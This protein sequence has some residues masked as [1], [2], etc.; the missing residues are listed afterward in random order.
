MQTRARARHLLAAFLLLLVLAPTR[1]DAY[2]VLTHEQII[3]L[4]WRDTIV[5]LLLSQYPNLTPKQLDEAHAYAYGGCAI[6]DLGY[7]PFGSIFFSDLT[8]YVRTG[9]FVRALFRNAQNAN[10]LAFAIGALSHYLGDTIGHAQAINTS[11]PVEFPKLRQRYGTSVSFAQGEHPHVQTEFAFDIN[12]VALHHLA[13]L[14]YLQHIGL[15]IPQPLLTRSFFEV[16]GVDIRHSLGGHRP[17]VRSYRFG[18]RTFIPRI[19]YAET[20]LHRHSFSP[21]PS[22]PALDAYLQQQSAVATAENWDTYRKKKAGIRTRLLAGLIFVLPKFGILSDLSIRGPN[23]QTEQTFIVSFNQSTAALRALLTQYAT[24]PSHLPNLDLDT[25]LTV[26]P[27]TYSLI[28]KTYATLLDRITQ[29]PG[30]TLPFSLQ[31]SILVFY[32]DPAAPILT[33]KN[34]VEWVR[35][36]SQLKILAAMQ[37]R[38]DPPL[39]TPEEEAPVTSPTAPA[40]STTPTPPTAP[41]APAAKPATTTP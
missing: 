30:V 2:S 10:E 26:R 41:A 9:D 31:Q 33:K 37:T 19:A 40:D 21:D 7:Y 20:L 36:Q 5:P 3:D 25:G 35:V 12:Q 34:P 14:A 24:L 4:A 8:H 11:V 27:G 23:P 17:T 1:L 28:D 6:Q 15:Q 22:S 39:P 32:A 18:V 38:Q 16:Y 29:R 13:P